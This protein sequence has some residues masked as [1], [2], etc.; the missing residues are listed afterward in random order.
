VLDHQGPLSLL[1]A[2]PCALLSGP[3]STTGRAL[4]RQNKAG[5]RDVHRD[6]LGN[7]DRHSTLA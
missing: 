2:L 6:H 5:G 1:C 3:G 7:T 4:Q